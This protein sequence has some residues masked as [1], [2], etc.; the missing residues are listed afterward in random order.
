M[1]RT[2]N[3]GFMMKLYRRIWYTPDGQ[4]ARRIEICRDTCWQVKSGKRF[5]LT[6]HYNLIRGD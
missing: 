4:S 6:T 2:I 3:H 5:E 1:S